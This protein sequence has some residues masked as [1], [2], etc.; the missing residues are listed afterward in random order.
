MEPK[1]DSLRVLAITEAAE[2]RLL[3]TRRIGLPTRCL[4]QGDRGFQVGNIEKDIQL[5]MRIIAMQTHLNERRLKPSTGFT[6]GSK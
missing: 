2:A 3:G 4:H 5:R 6:H 1:S